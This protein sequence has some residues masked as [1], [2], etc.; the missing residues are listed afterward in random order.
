MLCLSKPEYQTHQ[1]TEVQD[2]N[3]ASSTI[4]AASILE[5]RESHTKSSSE[6]SLDLGQVVVSQVEV[7]KKL[8]E[9]ITS[10]NVLEKKLN[11]LLSTISIPHD[12]P[13]GT[14]GSK[15]TAGATGGAKH[16]LEEA[17]TLD[18]EGATSHQPLPANVSIR[19]HLDTDDSFPPTTNTTMATKAMAFVARSLTVQ[20]ST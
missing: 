5:L 4:N 15:M 18:Q 11:I 13:P 12:F 7:I 10:Y 20:Q 16:N 17:T 19:Q 6:F 3:I 14:L 9:N 2:R 1:L 8:E